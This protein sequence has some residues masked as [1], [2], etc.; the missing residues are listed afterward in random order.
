MENGFIVVRNKT[1][2]TDA[3]TEEVE[4]GMYAAV[5]MLI[6]KGSYD[7]GLILLDEFLHLVPIST[8]RKEE[9]TD[10]LF[11][12]FKKLFAGEHY[13]KAAKYAAYVLKIKR[14]DLR[15]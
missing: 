2:H 3:V 13:E 4:N 1:V 9:I 7:N 12:T 6:Q 10:L 14:A 8:E 15:K 5:T 11:S